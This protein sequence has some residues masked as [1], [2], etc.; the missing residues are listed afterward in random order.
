MRI[1]I[2]GAGIAGLA[3]ARELQARGIDYLIVEKATAIAA[4]GAGITLASN[5]LKCLSS[6][7]DLKSLRAKGQTLEL[8]Q[9]R[10]DSGETLSTL[11]TKLPRDDR[12]GIAIHRYRLHETLLEGLDSAKILLGVSI[13]NFHGDHQR[14]HAVLSNGESVEVD[15]LVGADGLKSAIRSYV[16]PDATIVF[17]GYTCWRTVVAHTLASP[18]QAVEA[19]GRGKRLGYLQIA[20]GELYI[21]LTLNVSKREYASGQ[22]QRT[23]AELRTIF[24]DFQAESASV[25]QLLTDDVPLIHNDLEEID[26][27]RWT[28]DR[29]VLIGDAAHAMTPNLG[30][31][32]AMGIEDAYTLA[33]FWSQDASPSS[34]ERFVEARRPRIRFMQNESRRT[35]RI[36]QW[37]SP[38][39]VWLR[40][41]VVKNLPQFVHDRLHQRI[42]AGVA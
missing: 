4:V 23:H 19:W 38:P 39:A 13:Q 29:V 28:K 20:P 41:A 10:S 9:L 32:A 16:D 21:Y 7:I 36:G 5:A 15:Y 17:S 33:N 18:T 8:M 31:G 3:L 1:L 35:G 25:V 30:Q 22:T 11:P 6:T 42:F 40:Q 2:Q 34:L 26:C 27:H 14:V 24:S 37:S 12:H